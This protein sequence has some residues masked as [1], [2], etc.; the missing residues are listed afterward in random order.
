MI[1]REETTSLKIS[2]ESPLGKQHMRQETGKIARI[3]SLH[4]QTPKKD[5]RLQAIQTQARIVRDLPV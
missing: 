2:L 4:N 1:K 5:Y 3:L